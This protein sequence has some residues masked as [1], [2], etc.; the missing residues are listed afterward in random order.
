MNVHI[1]T[2]RLILRDFQIEDAPGIFA[3]DTDLE[4]MRY[5]GGVKMKDLSEAEKTIEHIQKQYVERGV[6]RLALIE[7]T[8]GEFVGWS[9]L[10]LESGELN[11]RKKWYD[12]GYRLLRKFWGM[13]YAT[14]SAIASLKYGF[15]ELKLA[16]I[17]AL[18]DI[19]NSGSNRVLQ[20]IKMTPQG[21]VQYY[22][23]T[24]YFYTLTKQTWQNQDEN[25]S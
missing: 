25:P 21:E 20:K 10:K 1:E 14:E 9:G 19:N 22:G 17:C 11:G 18:A 12:L 5:L 7:K 3:L 16:E 13:G 24:C 8:T 2:D 6:G 15:E 23:H 4:V